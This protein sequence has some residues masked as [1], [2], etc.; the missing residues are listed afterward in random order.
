[1]KYKTLAC[2][3]VLSSSLVLGQKYESPDTSLLI[4]KFKNLQEHPRL[5]L[6][7][8]RVLSIKNKLQSDTLLQQLVEQVHSYA[9]SALNAPLISYEF[10]DDRYESLNP[11]RRN[12]MFRA[13][14]C[15][16][17]YQLT[18]DTIYAARVRD[19][20]IAASAFPDWGPKKFLNIGELSAFAGIGYD[21]VYDYLKEDEKEIIIK[22]IVKHS[23]SEG[24]SAYAGT[25]PNGWWINS[26]N[27]WNQVC[28]AGMSLAALAIA[29]DIPD[30][31]AM[32]VNRALHYIPG[33]MAGYIPDGAWFEGPTY[34]AYG[35]TYNG[36]LFSALQTSLDT[37]FGLDKATGYNELG[38]SGSFHIHTVGPT[39]LYN[40]FGDSKSTLYF[41]PVLFW[42]SHHYNIPAYAW[43]ERM[44]IKKD[45]PRMKKGILMSDDTLDRFLALLVAWYNDAGQE[46]TYDD[47]PLD[48][49]FTGENSAIGALHSEWSEDAI[50]LGFKGGKPG[51]NHAH[52]DIGSF[53]LD[54]GGERWAV[55]L[56][57][58]DY[59]LPG[60][61]D[62]EG[63]RWD[64]YRLNNFG[65]NTLVI[66]NDKQFFNAAANI[67]DFYSDPDSAFATVDMTSAY[68]YANN[69]RRTFT[70]IDRTSVK[71]RDNIQA[72]YITTDV[73]WGMVT[74]ADIELNYNE[75]L[76]RKNGK[77]LKVMINQPEDAAFELIST[78]PD[79]HR[80]NQ[81]E[82]TIMLGIN[83][84]MEAGKDF[85]YEVKLVPNDS[86]LSVINNVRI[87]RNEK[88]PVS[89]YPNPFK[90]K[91]SIDL[92]N[93]QS[94]HV[95]IAIYDY[96]GRLIFT[97]DFN[98]KAS[99]VFTWNGINGSGSLVPA[100]I[101]LLKIQEG[102][103]QVIKKL[104]KK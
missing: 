42:M 23:L 50:Y 92:S 36:M 68:P 104:I 84:Q 69:T 97:K 28:N 9:D 17:I 13:F 99:S 43:F 62:R 98:A 20:L 100:G 41:S 64:Y 91:T 4:S 88:I 53:V 32:I 61:F 29:E 94:S 48:K 47:F 71:I 102:N 16:L 5:I 77:V 31:A 86:A 75:A 12:A 95:R 89:I 87:A 34:W 83:H 24:L 18:G 1:M 40:N 11:Q 27:N 74:S 8:R 25:H 93:V 19:E 7:P 21:W 51:A 79:D 55:D 10:E 73:R 60:Y 35:T 78:N 57:K 37:L 54:A 52:M 15:G 58:D 45:L 80:Q 38:E 3:L 46:L 22:G 96:S 59:N 2:L 82:G 63:Q 76:L 70:M 90:E 66:N 67:V 39:G 30:T 44:L 14:N 65:H 85:V 56:G 33:A 101:Y 72:P 81:N 26:V 49:V 103:N 6:T